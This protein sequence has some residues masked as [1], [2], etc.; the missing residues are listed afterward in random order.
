MVPNNSITRFAKR[1]IK[2]FTAMV[3][4]RSLDTRYKRL[5]TL[6]Q[7]GQLLSNQCVLK[8]DGPDGSEF[9]TEFRRV[10]C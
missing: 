1:L 7:E 2:Y 3:P 10:L 5:T 8:I 9:G 4:V 6:L